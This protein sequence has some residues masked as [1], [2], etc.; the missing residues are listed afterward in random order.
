MTLPSGASGLAPCL[1]YIGSDTVAELIKKAQEA[2]YDALVVVDVV[3]AVNRVTRV[4]KNDAQLRLINLK[5]GKKAFVSTS[6]SNVTVAKEKAASRSDGVE[7]AVDVFV[8]KTEEF[9]GLQEIP[10]KLTAEIITSKRLPSL[11]KDKSKSKIDRLS[12]VNY[13]FSK[14]LISG[15]QREEAYTAI[16]GNVGV[17]LAN[18]SP[19]EKFEVVTKMLEK[20]LD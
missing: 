8:K 2:G 15:K 13:Y 5:D 19:E 4:V 20:E 14:N 1:T 12:E 18:G 11:C 10:E 9:F 6:F 17:T 16:A 7:K 3:V